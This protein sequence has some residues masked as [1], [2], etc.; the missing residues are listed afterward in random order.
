MV[1]GSEDEMA[2]M[3][4]MTQTRMRKV[5]R[6]NDDQQVA[7]IGMTTMN[8]LMGMPTMMMP[9]VMM[10]ETNSNGKNHP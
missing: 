7:A 9:Q 6:C 2:I 4:M 3:A 5:P 8:T 10:T 1:E